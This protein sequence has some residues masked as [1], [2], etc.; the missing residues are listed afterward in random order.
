M[1]DAPG[2]VVSRKG[3]V[4]SVI[5]TSEPFWPIDTTYYLS[6]RQSL[7][8]RWLDWRMSALPLGS[9]ASSTSVPGLNRNDAYQLTVTTPHLPEQRHIA[10]I[11]DTLDEAIRKTE[12]VI[13]KL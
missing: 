8:W 13:A 12:Q 4:G 5:W 2:I 11:L 7:D 6:A 1:I 3:T 9:L 10:K